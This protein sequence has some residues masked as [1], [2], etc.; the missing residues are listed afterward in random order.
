MK[1]ERLDIPEVVLITPVVFGDPRGFFFESYR[2]D[3]FRENGIE[4]EFVQDNHS[5]STAGTLRGLHYQL[6]PAAQAKLVRAARGSIFDVAVDI[7]RD[8]PTFGKWVGAT[9]SAD[10][11][12]MLFVPAGFAH[13]F[14]SLEDDTEVLYKAGDYYSP[15]HE[16][17]ILWNDADLA[18][19]WPDVGR[20]YIISDKDAASPGFADA[21]LG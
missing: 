20:D 1:F 17:S 19:T 8:S 18:I 11:R 16:R 4:L 7:R 14:L 13:G 9:L 6:P 12:A 5:N 2:R 3:R 15:E 10:N 21:E